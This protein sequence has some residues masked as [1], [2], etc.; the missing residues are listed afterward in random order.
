MSSHITHPMNKH[1]IEIALAIVLAS[2]DSLLWLI[3][4]LAG[5]HQPSTITII[6]PHVQPLFHLQ[7]C[8]VRQLRVMT[9]I[10]SKG[11]RKH[12]LLALAIA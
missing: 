6:K 10:K 4:E 5:F 11:I 9:N 12:Q 1:P 7:S 8:T 2:V 3:N